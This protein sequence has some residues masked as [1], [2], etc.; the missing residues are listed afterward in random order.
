[1]KQGKR[2]EVGN[3]RE[4]E[5]KDVKRNGR[6]GDGQNSL[7]GGGGEIKERH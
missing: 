4:R 1:M 3:K 7:I 5:V 6:T 2:G